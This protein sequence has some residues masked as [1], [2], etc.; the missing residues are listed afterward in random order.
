MKQTK[1]QVAAA[2]EMIRE[3]ADTIKELDIVVS[4]Q[5]YAHLCGV[6][7]IDDYHKIIGIL[8]RSG[9]VEQKGHILTWKG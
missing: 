3:V 5:L 6:L 9:L 8:T 1:E 4:G 2:L 7:S